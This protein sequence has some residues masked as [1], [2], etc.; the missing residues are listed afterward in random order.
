MDWLRM[1]AGQ[2]DA[3]QC[4]SRKA[5]EFYQTAPETMFPDLMPEQEDPPDVADLP[6]ADGALF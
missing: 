5:R 1:R 3:S 2:F 4:E 6:P